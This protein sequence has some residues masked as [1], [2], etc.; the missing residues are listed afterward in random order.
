MK[1]FLL[2]IEVQ[3]NILIL[4]DLKAI[5]VI[6]LSILLKMNLREILPKAYYKYLLLLNSIKAE[7]YQSHMV[8]KHEIQH[9]AEPKI[10]RIY[11]LLARKLDAIK[12]YIQKTSIKRK[13]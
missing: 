4:D 10:G 9:I 1:L 8:F 11:K 5:Q 7:K 2:T 12:Q 3:Q 6:V 13:I